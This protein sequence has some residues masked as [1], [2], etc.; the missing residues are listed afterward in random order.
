[1]RRWVNFFVL[2]TTKIDASSTIKIADYYYNDVVLRPQELDK[3]CCYEVKMN[4]EKV[5]IPNKKTAERESRVNFFFFEEHPSSKI[6]CMKRR[7]HV[8]IPQIT[9]TK[10]FPNISQLQMNNANPSDDVIAGS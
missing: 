4:F 5:K 2:R 7:K 6:M 8:V 1:M 3:M 10:H 9:S